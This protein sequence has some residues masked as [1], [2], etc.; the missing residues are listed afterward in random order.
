MREFDALAAIGLGITVASTIISQQA[1]ASAEKDA[2]EATARQLRLEAASISQQIRLEQ[3]DLD[4]ST[5]DLSVT[6]ER[7]LSRIRAV[8]AANGGGG[9]SSQLARNIIG[10]AEGEFAITETRLQQDTT[11]RISS[12][13][14]R[15]SELSASASATTAAGQSAAGAAGVATGLTLIS[16]ALR[17]GTAAA[18]A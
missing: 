4:R 13:R 1:Q 16:G 15:K 10:E 11:I 7:Q 9:L 17:I 14:Q 6:R 5:R 18:A 3:V 8:L 12:L 2:A